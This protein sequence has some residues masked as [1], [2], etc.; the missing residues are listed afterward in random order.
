MSGALRVG[1]TPN[2]ART[3]RSP[4]I[5]QPAC[6]A[7]RRPAAAADRDDQAGI[8]LQF[9]ARLSSDQ[10][11]LRAGRSRAVTFAA[12]AGARASRNGLRIVPDEVATHWPPERLVPSFRNRRPAEALDR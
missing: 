11:P 4:H 5:S 6:G 10:L 8:E 9:A 2:P 1:G 7:E 3:N 12:T